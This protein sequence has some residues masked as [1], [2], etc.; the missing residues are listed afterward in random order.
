[1]Q[2]Q[3]SKKAFNDN[4]EAL[5][6]DFYKRH[7]DWRNPEGVIENKL[8]ELQTEGNIIR[9]TGNEFHNLIKESVKSLLNEVVL[10]TDYGDI[11]FHGN[12]AYDWAELAKLRKDKYN[13]ASKKTDALHSKGREYIANGDRAMADNMFDLAHATSKQADKEVDNWLRNLKNAKDLGYSPKNLNN[14]ADDRL[15]REKELYNMAMS[16]KTPEEKQKYLQMY[17]DVAGDIEGRANANFNQY[18]ELKNKL[19]K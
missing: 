6:N 1:L 13:F 18:I 15:A 9:M 17:N 4:N 11:S 14:I 12:N 5:M 8:Y 16:A 2:Q 3:H 7:P 19:G 10:H